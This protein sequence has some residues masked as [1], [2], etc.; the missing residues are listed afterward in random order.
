MPN[1]PLTKTTMVDEMVD[2]DPTTY[3]LL[4]YAWVILLA[5]WGGVANHIG[6]VRRREI[7]R[8]RLVELIGDVVTSGFTGILT[9]YLCEAA[10]LDPLM[11]AAFVGVS[12]HMGSRII[13][14]ME[15]LLTRWLAPKDG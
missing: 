2:K 1:K 9:F 8:F 4:T 10:K 13:F 6:K 11:T 15:K 12:G 7:P 3:S 14:K 5:A